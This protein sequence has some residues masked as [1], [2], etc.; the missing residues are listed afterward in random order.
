M[1]NTAG[2]AADEEV[3]VCEVQAVQFASHDDYYAMLG[4]AHLARIATHDQIRKA[5]KTSSV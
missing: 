3:F 2:S 1:H 4:I 5:C